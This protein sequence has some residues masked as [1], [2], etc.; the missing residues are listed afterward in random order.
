MVYLPAGTDTPT[1]R[2]SVDTTS[3]TEDGASL[4]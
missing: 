1:V 3:L 2:L 4:R